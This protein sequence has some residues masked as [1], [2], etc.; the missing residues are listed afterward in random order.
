M[1]GQEVAGANKAVVGV[2][3]VKVDNTIDY[4]KLPFIA[5]LPQCALGALQRFPLK[6]NREK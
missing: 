3:V 2:N 4:T 1:R 6:V 5:D